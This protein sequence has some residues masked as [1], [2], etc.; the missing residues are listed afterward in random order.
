MTE[1][2]APIRAK[3]WPIHAPQQPFATD[4]ES[5][6]N[7]FSFVN[8][9]PNENR[10]AIHYH[11]D[12]SLL[13]TDDILVR[14][15]GL[16]GPIIDSRFDGHQPIVE[17][18]MLTP[19]SLK[20]IFEKPDALVI[21]FNSIGYDAPL[22]AFMVDFVNTYEVL[23]S[24]ELIRQVSDL[25]INAPR[26]FQTWPE[27]E[28]RAQNAKIYFK[29]NTGRRNMRPMDIDGLMKGRKLS[30]GES[31]WAELLTAWINS[32][33]H[34][35]VMLLN[36]VKSDASKTERIGLKRVAAQYGLQ[37]VEPKLRI[38]L[39]D[40]LVDIDAQQLNE[41]LPYNASDT[42]VTY[43]IFNDPVFQQQ[44]AL[45]QNMIEKYNDRFRNR[46][47]INSTNAQLVKFYVAPEE[48]LVDSHTIDTFFPVKGPEYQNLIDQ[49]SATYVTG[50]TTYSQMIELDTQWTEWLQY[51]PGYEPAQI[52]SPWTGEI[53]T[54]PRY[55]V[56]FG[57]LQQDLLEYMRETHPS[58]PEEAYHYYSLYRYASDRKVLVDQFVEA[59]PE[60][61]LGFAYDYKKDAETGKKIP[62]IYYEYI[63]PGS[64][65]RITCSIGGVH[66]DVM[67]ADQ[68][69]QVVDSLNRKTEILAYLQQTF[70]TA[71]DVKTWITDNQDAI[72]HPQLGVF[73]P[74]DFITK[75]SL[76]TVKFKTIPKA[77]ARKDFVKIVDLIDI[78]HADVTS[79]Y[80]SI[81]ILLRFLAT[82]NH[83]NN[84][85]DDPY[86][87]QRDIRVAA[88]AIASAVAKDD[89]TEVEIEAESNQILAKLFLNNASG[90]MD[91]SYNSP[92]KMNRNA[93]TMRLVGQLILLDIVHTVAELGGESVSTNTDGVYLVGISLETLID[94][95]NK[96]QDHYGLEAEPELVNRFVSK[97]A[98]NRYEVLKGG[99]TRNASGAMLSNFDSM[100]Y[101]K[102]WTQ[103]PIIDE[104][105]INYFDTHADVANTANA[106]IDRE[107][108]AAF[109]KSRIDTLLSDATTNKDKLDTIIRLCMPIQLGANAVAFKYLGVDANQQPIFEPLDKVSRQIFTKHGY[110]LLA[111]NITAVK[112]T[113]GSTKPYVPTHLE[114]QLLEAAILNGKVPELPL[115][116]A[117]I[118]KITNYSL[119][120]CTTV[121][122]DLTTLIGHPVWHDIDIDAYVEFTCK[123]LDSWSNLSEKRVKIKKLHLIT[124]K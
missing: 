97:D 66:G 50:Q 57:D 59:Y 17:F 60:P 14:A 8:Y 19:Q 27:L 124:S 18:H 64:D 24:T 80:P 81:I 83:E 111:A 56:K 47:N 52:K 53:Q 16:F 10:F 119:Q 28:L 9:Y 98:N 65:M 32:N 23:P 5:I 34:A 12:L 58:F 105:I 118:A 67:M 11:G 92:I 110:P 79:L 25:L 113:T 2:T 85:W 70:P 48:G 54:F 51:Q 117:K 49:I 73:A 3:R 37:V 6:H 15:N 42:F 89:W 108:I 41:L 69:N 22:L 109:I 78:L 114:S 45:R 86:A 96:W 55:C 84:S 122:E 33:F 21:G 88:K 30:W 7:V 87:L 77:P 4:V 120:R 121:N 68:Y 104:A 82:W 44:L 76:A 106:D 39:S 13:N 107:S 63:I 116:Q 91:S 31:S 26:A 123:Q 101:V 102:K 75:G 95:V 103:P 99:K 112:K 94:V 90:E 36:P 72:D 20:L 93:A 40:S 100:T 1:I 71:R 61:P 74:S 115:K 29:Q 62:R 35:D 43:Y 38:D 46:V